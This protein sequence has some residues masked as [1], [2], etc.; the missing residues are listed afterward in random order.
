MTQQQGT[1]LAIACPDRTCDEPP[2][3]GEAA[4]FDHRWEIHRVDDA[5]A[6]REWDTLTRQAAA[7]EAPTPPPAGVAAAIRQRR[8][9]TPSPAP[10]T[11]AAPV[12][13]TPIRKTLGLKKGE[14][15]PGYV[16]QAM[17]EQG[18]TPG[19]PAAPAPAKEAPMPCS[20]CDGTG[21]NARGCPKRSPAE[22]A[23]KAAKPCGYCKRTG[24]HTEKCPRGAANGQAATGGGTA[25]A[26][27]AAAA[28]AANGTGIAGAIAELRK[29]RL[30]HHEAIEEIDDLIGR[31]EKVLAP[32]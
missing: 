3:T 19:L 29:Q 6:A 30:G 18:L 32:A 23:A 31:L 15:L 25:K 5:T 26:K 12:D 10:A 4:Y 13:V 22:K 27:P 11:S 24:G 7:L 16:T 1:G 14:P 20:K 17:A 9:V 28:A 21:H 8:A 2:M